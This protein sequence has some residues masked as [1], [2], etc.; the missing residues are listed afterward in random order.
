MHG[1]CNGAQL[2]WRI[3]VGEQT[4]CVPRM[5]A[6]QPGCSVSARTQ[7]L[8]SAV[9]SLYRSTA[10][11]AGLAAASRM[12][13]EVL[14]YCWHCVRMVIMGLSSPN[15][16]SNLQRFVDIF[17]SP[18]AEYQMLCNMYPHGVIVC[19]VCWAAFSYWC[20]AVLCLLPWYGVSAVFPL[21][22]TAVVRFCQ[23]VNPW[24]LSCWVDS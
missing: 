6:M 3:T 15:L 22:S 21:T 17:A 16:Q 4:G 19:A 11:L 8:L 23:Q 12:I 5:H 10:G 14:C 20:H 2:V 1:G 13:A 24:L 18:A 9:W 7:V